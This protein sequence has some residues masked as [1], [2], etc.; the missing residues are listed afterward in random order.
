MGY[1]ISKPGLILNMPNLLI[2]LA[3]IVAA[4]TV[5][6]FAHALVADRLGD[7]TPR[8]SGR[9]SLN[10][11]AHLDPLGT[12]MLFLVRFGWGKPVPI[13]P[14]NFSHPRRDETLVSLAGPFSNLLLAFVISRLIPFLPNFAPFLY[15][16]FLINLYIAFFNLLP[17]PPL[18][19]SKIFLN[20][21]PV[22][23][24]IE[25]RQAL[26]QYGPILLIALALLPIGGANLIGLILQPPVVFLSR[27]LLP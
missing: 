2:F 9:L 3:I 23:K 5:H 7:P 17:V 24:S 4:I 15:E 11:L 6:E 16:F 13:D 21:I 10:P 19:G 26:N 1:T 18:D 14:Y 12:I 27:L 25:W 22:D 8:A 20:L